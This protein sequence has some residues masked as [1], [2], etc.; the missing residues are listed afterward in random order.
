MD[1]LS[2]EDTAKFFVK[3][4]FSFYSFKKK[5]AD[6]PQPY[7]KGGKN[8]Y[9]KRELKEWAKKHRILTVEDK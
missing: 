5:S 8:F 3:S 4:K 7:K 6:F 9:A 1:F 2:I